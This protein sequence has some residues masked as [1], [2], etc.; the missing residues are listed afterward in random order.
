MNEKQEEKEEKTKFEHK[1]EGQKAVDA[2]F[3]AMDKDGLLVDPEQEEKDL[4][5]RLRKL[6]HEVD[7]LKDLMARALKVDKQNVLKG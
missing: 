6:E 2:L 3:D 7:L 1:V 4:K 5:K